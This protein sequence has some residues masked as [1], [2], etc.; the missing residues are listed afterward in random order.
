MGTG[1]MGQRGRNGIARGA[2]VGGHV[3]LLLATGML[4]V[5]ATEELPCLDPGCDPAES[6][7]WL[8]G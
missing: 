8:L 5:A 2:L 7:L 1:G 3:W 6:E 4:N